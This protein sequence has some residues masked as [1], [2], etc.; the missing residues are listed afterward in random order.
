MIGQN[1]A[2]IVNSFSTIMTDNYVQIVWVE[3]Q[4]N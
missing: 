3:A 4:L 1:I 2:I